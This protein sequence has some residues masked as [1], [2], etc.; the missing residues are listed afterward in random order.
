M[1]T[2]RFD[3]MRVLH[4]SCGDEGKRWR[5]H[6]C[7][8]ATDRISIFQRS[9]LSIAQKVRL[10]CDAICASFL[11]PNDDEVGEWKGFRT[12]RDL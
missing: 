3:P 1:L 12:A 7:S 4:L 2:G 5:Y 8:I 9:S 6:L 10:E 11:S